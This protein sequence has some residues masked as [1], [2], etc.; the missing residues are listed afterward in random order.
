MGNGKPRELHI[1]KALDVIDF[2]GK[3]IKKDN[4]ANT[5]DVKTKICSTDKFSVYL[6]CIDG[7]ENFTQDKAYLNCSVIEGKGRFDGV[8]ITAGDSFILPYKYGNF[9]IEGKLKIISSHV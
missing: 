9:T 6:L 1:E 4:Y 8:E 7:C 5:K 3:E 2:T